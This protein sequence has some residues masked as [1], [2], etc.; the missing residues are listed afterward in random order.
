[1]TQRDQT[2]RNG[3]LTVL[4]FLVITVL[5]LNCLNQVRHLWRGQPNLG[6]VFAVVV[7]VA[8]LTLSVLS[9]MSASG[10]DR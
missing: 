7:A 4:H 3:L 9:R 8:L 6:N 1:M 10:Q 2:R 5:L